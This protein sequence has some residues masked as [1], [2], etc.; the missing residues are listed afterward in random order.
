MIKRSGIGRDHWASVGGNIHFLEWM[1]TK[2]ISTQIGKKQDKWSNEVL[3][4]QMNL[5]KAHQHKKE[6][7][8]Q[9]KMVGD[10]AATNIL[11]GLIRAAIAFNDKEIVR[12]FIYLPNPDAA[13]TTN[14]QNLLWQIKDAIPTTFLKVLSEQPKCVQE[15][16]IRLLFELLE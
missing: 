8:A 6:L 7:C 15:D 14:K 16:T 3:V 13:G 9:F 5:K 11:D 10:D 4:Y 2:S 12:F 1:E